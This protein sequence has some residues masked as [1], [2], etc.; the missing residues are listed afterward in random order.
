MKMY[1]KDGREINA[2][3]EQREILESSGWSLNPPK[4]KEK[5]KKVAET[6]EESEEET[7]TPVKKKRVIKKL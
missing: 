3:K 6:T 4:I 7:T 1:N 5:T 2:T